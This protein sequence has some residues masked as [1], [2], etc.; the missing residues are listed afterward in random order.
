MCGSLGMVQPL[1][2]GVVGVEYPVGVQDPGVMLCLPC[3]SVYVRPW[4]W[5]SQFRCPRLVQVG[6]GPALQKCPQGGSISGHTQ[7]SCPAGLQP[8]T[9][10]KPELGAGLGAS[11]PWSCP[12]CA[13]YHRAG[14]LWTVGWGDRKNCLGMVE[15]PLDVIVL[16]HRVPHS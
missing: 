7:V 5:L 11:G 4:T 8:A 15:G 2:P 10:A 16:L 3:V 14:D 9:V 13:L 12:L 6:S 1:G